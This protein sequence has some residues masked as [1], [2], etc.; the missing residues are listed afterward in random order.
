MTERKIMDKMPDGR[1]VMHLGD[2]VYAIYE[3]QGIW[4]HANSHD[5]PT[6]RIW[7]ENCVLDL[8]LP[9]FIEACRK[10]S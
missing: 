3:A 10:S 7:L 4:L 1:P 6:D 2:G 8:A 5:K 9:L